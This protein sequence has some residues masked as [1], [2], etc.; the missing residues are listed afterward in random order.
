MT[1]IWIVIVAGVIGIIFFI[2]QTL[3]NKKKSQVVDNKKY[4]LLQIDVPK[5]NDKTPLAAQQMFAAIHGIYRDPHE[6]KFH[7]RIQEHLSF[8][9]ISSE[10]SIRFYAYVPETL[11]SYIEGQIYAQYPKVSIQTVEDY[12]NNIN[13]E[14][15]VVATADVELT[16][17]QFYPIKTFPNFEVDPLAGITSALTESQDFENLWIQIVIEP[18]SDEWTQDGNSYVDSVRS[19]K[20]KNGGFGKA[21][22]S[23]TLE[24]GKDL[25]KT[26]MNPEYQKEMTEKSDEKPELPSTLEE[27]LKAIETKTTLLGYKTKMRL[28]VVSN[29]AE[30]A[31]NKLQNLAGVFKQFTTT[32]QNGFVVKNIS[33]ND[34]GAISDYK[35]RA[36]DKNAY[37]LNIEELASIFH[38]PSVTV[39]TPN[40]VW[41]GSKRG[42]SPSNLP[43]KGKV[44]AD[45]LTVFAKTDFRNAVID[46]GIK[47]DD[48]RKHTYVVGKTGV[49]KSTML[50]NMAMDDIR[51]GRG[52]AFIDPHGDPY[53]RVLKNIPEHRIKDVVIFD[54]SDAEHPIGFNLLEN[55]NPE[56]KTLV[57]SGMIGIFQKIWAFTWGPRLEHILRNAIMA[58]M[59][60]PNST[61]IDILRI[62]SDKTFRQSVVDTIQD[63][64]IREF[65]T[66]EF[67]GYND[68][69]RSEAIAPIQN[70]VGQFVSSP[71]IRNIIGQP[72]STIDLDEI[73]NGNK[74]L[75]VNLSKGKIGEDNSALLG[76]M[77][78]TKI[79]LAAMNR[80]YMD[81]DDRKDF[82]MYVDE[83]QN[84]A[85]ESFATIFSEAR[86]YKLSIIVANQ[87]IAQMPEEVR[88]A[89]FGNVGTIITF[90]V[91]AQDAPYLAKEMAP[92][93][94]ETDL[95]NLDKFHIYVKM[96]IDGVT[97]PAFSAITLPPITADQSF[98]THIIENSRTNNTKPR[99]E[100]EKMIEE[101][102]QY[103]QTPAGK[104][105]PEQ[106]EKKKGKGPSAVIRANRK[107][108]YEYVDSEGERWYQ[109]EPVSTVILSD[110]EESPQKPAGDSR[111]DAEKIISQDS[112]VAIQPLEINQ[113]NEVP[114]NQENVVHEEPTINSN[115]HQIAHQT[116]QATPPDV[117]SSAN[118]KSQSNI[119]PQN[120]VLTPQPSA[121]LPNIFERPEADK[122]EEQLPSVKNTDG[123][124]IQPT[125]IE[126][127][128]PI[129]ID[130]DK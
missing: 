119:I 81:E 25:V 32:N 75:L 60:Y 99:D 130:E 58:L 6:V 91:G 92:V 116:P 26:I 82:F 49:G 38:L 13:L 108:W 127:N 128:K 83:F 113:A 36:I 120:S 39:E 84:F 8:E 56:M 16:K 12:T 117:I 102:L 19:G 107:R 69:L 126:P 28:A 27:A 129:H 73:I 64:V 43:I 105:E 30:D 50:E 34:I 9:I 110:G 1:I 11:K 22:A 47:T 90:R 101:S 80:A 61:M 95:I 18:A 46:F 4:L 125:I 62:L 52:I 59:D 85:T 35:T 106:Q 48:R 124:S 96:S 94:D 40:I 33:I 98:S 29:T 86:K 112:T 87:Y 88:D 109:E 54:P 14:Q 42:E 78:I 68:K 37:I 67:E 44:P 7:E 41:A 55:I 65:W 5:D 3:K 45:E 122:V 103:N 118:E 79:Q 20:S 97:S 10:K 115:I 104:T 100:V 123:T 57:V 114:A 76:A 51:E 15:K 23:G 77:L 111:L 17:E 93:F 72:K 21:I 70:K 121:S 63:P 71:I 24:L 53:E 2:Y 89:V 66:K 31:R 74:I